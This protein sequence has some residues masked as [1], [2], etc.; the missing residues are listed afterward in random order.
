MRRLSL[1]VSLLLVVVACAPPSQ[2]RLRD[3]N[4]LGLDEYTRGDFRHARECFQAALALKP[5][6]PTLL[7]NIGQCFDHTD[8]VMGAEQYYQASLRLCPNFAD[9][10]H[11]YVALL[12]RTGRRDQAT[13]FVQDW[14]AT[15]PGL[16]AAYAEEGWLWLQEGDLPR[17]QAR[18]QQALDLNP[19]DPNTLA[20]LG[21]VYEAMQRP[22]RALA[23]YEQVLAM[24][25]NQ[26]DVAARIQA[27]RNRGVSL[28]Q[29]D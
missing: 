3:Y 12:L 22:D 4:E 2:E 25:P 13:R 29:P 26:V 7:Y 14:Q 1:S 23:L 24:N 27:L 15:A 9:C 28:P 11:A 5:D 19:H 6:D 21:Q 18:L 16:A 20:D 8:N 10:R 17:A